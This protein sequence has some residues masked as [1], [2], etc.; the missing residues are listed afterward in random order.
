MRAEKH[1]YDYLLFDSQGIEKN[2]AVALDASSEVN[3]Y[4]KLPKGFYID[5]PVGKYNPDWAIAFNEGTV[6]YIYFVAETKGSNSTLN[7]RDTEDAKIK[8]ARKHFHAIS[9]DNVK[10]EVLTSYAELMNI[11]K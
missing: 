2:F 10:Y 7:F 1:L 9:T 4:V 8:C 5:M 6:K 3:V 11:V